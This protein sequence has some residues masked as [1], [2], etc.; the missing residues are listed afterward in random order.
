MD[1]EKEVVYEKNGRIAFGRNTN[2][3]I[4]YIGGPITNALVFNPEDTDQSAILLIGTNQIDIRKFDFTTITDIE[5]NH[6][7]YI[8]ED[9]IK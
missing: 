3:Y 9:Q 4:G 6:V 8:R 1:K 2:N 5:I 7:R